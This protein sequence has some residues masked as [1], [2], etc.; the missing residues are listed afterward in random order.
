MES[1]EIVVSGSLPRPEIELSPAAFNARQVALARA[2]QVTEILS[3]TDLDDAAAA[4][5]TIKSLSRSVEAS[6]K[7]VKAPV[8]EVG[9]RIDAIANEFQE[10]LANESN[11]LSILVGSYQEAQKRKAERERAEE[12]RKQTEAME[13]MQV[14][15]RAAMEAGDVEAADEARAE[16]A[17]KIAE[18]QLKV[19]KTEGPRLSGVSTRSNWKFELVNIDALYA[20]RPDLCIVS[21]NASAIRAIVKATNGKPIPG[22][23]IWSE[24]GAI[25]RS[26]PAPKV[27]SF[28]Y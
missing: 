20:A 12:A 3:V 16:A 1:L 9:K 11:R 7:E 14:K 26:A 5:T 22:L 10:P 27:E 2:S 18:S 24:A 13:E 23:R 6:R 8:I 25:V 4:L 21:E 15:Q 17:D 28:D 19:I